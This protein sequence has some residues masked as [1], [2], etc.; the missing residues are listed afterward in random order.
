MP[1]G[2]HDYIVNGKRVIE[3][4]ME[5]YQITTHKESGISN[6]PN[7]WVTEVCNPRYI[8]SGSLDPVMLRG[9]SCQDF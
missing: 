7:D 1:S 8:L 6:N 3:W 5:R 4:I 9:F 2:D